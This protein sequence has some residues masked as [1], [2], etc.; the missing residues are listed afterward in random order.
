MLSR[1]VD[2]NDRQF[3]SQEDFLSCVLSCSDAIDYHVV[4]NLEK[5]MYLHYLDV[6]T[7]G[8]RVINN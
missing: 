8:D 1:S 2:A 7:R 3:E 5:S 4:K 6:A